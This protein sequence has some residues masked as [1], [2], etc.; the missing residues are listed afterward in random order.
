MLSPTHHL[1]LQPQPHLPPQPS[2]SEPA[3][4][5]PHSRVDNPHASSA[6][7]L[8]RPKF[9]AHDQ[10]HSQRSEPRS[11]PEFAQSYVLG[12]D[13]QFGDDPVEFRD[14]SSFEYEPGPEES[15]H[16]YSHGATHD[17]LDR[18]GGDQPSV[19]RVSIARTSDRVMAAMRSHA[20]ALDAGYSNLNSAVARSA[21]SQ[22]PL[23]ALS[24]TEPL[25]LFRALLNAPAP[26]C[27]PP[28]V[29]HAMSSS[30]GVALGLRVAARANMAV[31]HGVHAE[32]HEVAM[33]PR[34][35]ARAKVPV[36]CA[37]AAARFHPNSPAAS[38]LGMPRLGADSSE[39]LAAEDAVVQHAHRKFVS[40][41]QNRLPLG[42][43]GA[44]PV[45]S[46]ASDAQAVPSVRRHKARTLR[47]PSRR[48]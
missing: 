8:H 36:A 48:K 6:R 46:M 19:P 16:V 11:Q 26:T 24:V 35:F 29:G 31:L 41:L 42:S 7:G 30:I 1:P 4:P 27:A 45:R 39:D 17:R 18:R 34:D 21:V 2:F 44:A 15:A 43:A 20:R 13:T 3:F 47:Q 25:D 32:S 14:R 12:G 9:G 10:L 40:A 37:L 22:I 38:H 23:Q 28:I 33:T 5:Q